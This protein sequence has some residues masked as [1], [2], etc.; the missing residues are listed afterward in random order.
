MKHRLLV[1]GSLDDLVKLTKLSV[2][3]G[4]Y[5]V[6]VD[7]NDGEAK[8]YASKSYKVDLNDTR[9]LDQIIREEKIDHVLTS[10]SDILFELM[11]KT[12]ERNML[13]C[14]CPPEKMRFLRDKMMMKRMFQELD[15]PSA[16]A[17][18]VTSE[19]LK[20]DICIPYPC[21]LKPLD[22]W[23]SRGLSIVHNDDELRLRLKDSTGFST[24]GYEAILESINMG[25]ELNVMSWIKDGNVF[26]IE[27][28]DRETSGMSADTLPHQSREIFP[29]IFYKELE[30][31]VKEYLIR[32]ADY[33]G[34]KEG[35]LSMQFF[36]ENG[37]TTVGEV[38]G[39]F[40]GYGQ[41]IVPII[42]DIDPNELLLNMIYSPEDNNRILEKT[43]RAFDHCSVA[44]YLLPKPGGIVRDLGNVMSFRNEHT[45]FF[46]VFAEPGVSTSFIP[47]IAWIYAHFGTREEADAYTKN[48]YE[49]LYVPDLYGNNLVMTNS[50]VSYDGKKWENI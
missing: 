47:W 42:N 14:F 20:Q 4:I 41:G 12:S 16:P 7:G 10:F 9:L 21:A 29:S 2:S 46:K 48:I 45:D 38:C 31:M 37:Q 22:G 34:I 36:Y 3:R 39:R 18:K 28:G 33:C 30:L 1:L 43:E 8:K 13:P 44:L 23:G 11:V 26:L 35:P 32:V 5:T 6:V 25:Y 49:N 24:S 27:F 17:Q 15:I 19:N 40:F 50:L